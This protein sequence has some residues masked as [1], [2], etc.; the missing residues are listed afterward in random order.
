MSD[1]LA[2]LE[3]GS[4]ALLVV[5]VQE[6]LMPAMHEA[7]ACM[8]GV[9]KMVD[10]AR[11]LEVPTLV[12]EQYPA[13]LGPTCAGVREGLGEVAAVAKVRFSAC[14]QPIEQRLAEL[15]RRQVIVVGVETHVCVQQTALDLL[16]GGYTVYVCADAVSSRRVLDREMALA[17]MRQAG[18]IVTTTESV[19]FEML[20]EAGSACFKQIQRIV[21]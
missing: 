3:R 19:I 6:K 17:R 2:R 1:G 18:A 7:E 13:G 9:R 15:K 5:D 20:G 11:V 12:T 16:R 14:V 10:A 4:A 21:K 8:A